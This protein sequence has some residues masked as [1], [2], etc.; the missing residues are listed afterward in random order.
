MHATEWIA[1]ASGI[2]ALAAAGISVWQARTASDSAEHSERQARAADEQARIAGEQLQQTERDHR[3]QL[4]LAEQIHREQSEPYVVVDLG[5]DRPGSGLLVLSIQNIGPTMAR[6][7]R[8]HVAPELEST[9]ARLT[10]RLQRALARTIPVLPPNRRLTY[11]FDTHRRWGSGLPMQFQFTVDAKGP[12]DRAVEQLTYTVD[13][14]VLADSLVGE[15]LNKKLEDALKSIGGALDGLTKAY[16]RTHAED[17]RAYHQRRV[18]ELRRQ[19]A[20]DSDT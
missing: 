5:P 7:V 16:E 17:I 15:P 18:E 10:P 1:V 20:D 9:E 19:A 12:G 3:E 6:D 2:V 11:T 8:I 14:D 13:L 4:Q